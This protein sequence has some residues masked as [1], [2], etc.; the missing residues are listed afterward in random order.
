MEGRKTG[1]LFIFEICYK[2][3]TE[4]VVNCINSISPGFFE[5][6]IIDNQDIIK[7][8]QAFRS[9]K[10]M[11]AT[12]CNALASKYSYVNLAVSQSTTKP[13]S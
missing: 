2:Y 9:R 12:L 1:L 13:A 6:V 4:M 3:N 8:I 5:A 11:Y 10:I 7:S